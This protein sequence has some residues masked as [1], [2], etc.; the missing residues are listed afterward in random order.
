MPK[1]YFFTDTDLLQN[2]TTASQAY[3][4]QGTALG[5]DIFQGY[6]LHTVSSGAN[7]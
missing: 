4:P 7:L 5:Q 6:N 1:Y 2:Q 3:G